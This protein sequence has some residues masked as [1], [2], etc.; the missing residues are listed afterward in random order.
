M[1]IATAFFEEFNMDTLL[2]LISCVTGIVALFISGKAYTKCN[3]LENSMNDNKSFSDNSADY[4]Q[5]AVGDIVNNGF[6]S[7]EVVAMTTTLANMNNDFNLYLPF[8]S[9]ISRYIDKTTPLVIN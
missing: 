2:A 5:K 3:K 1:F 7:E 6:R 4:S 8:Q 9:I